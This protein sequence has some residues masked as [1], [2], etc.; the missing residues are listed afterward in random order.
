MT[1]MTH[2]L[3]ES[4]LGQSFNYSPKK[5]LASNN[6]LLFTDGRRDYERLRRFMKINIYKRIKSSDPERS[7]EGKF[8]WEN[9]EASFVKNELTF[10]FSSS[11][12][13]EY[14]LEI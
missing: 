10:W 2:M 4:L 5:P 13:F 3:L 1:L 8:I 12:D 11:H 14:F 6:F 9:F 7:K